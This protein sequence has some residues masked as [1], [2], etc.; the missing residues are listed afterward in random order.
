[1]VFNGKEGI[2]SRGM[3]VRSLLVRVNGPMDLKEEANI[4]KVKQPWWL[5][6]PRRPRKCS[7]LWCEIGPCALHFHKEHQVYYVGIT[8]M[9]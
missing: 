9:K 4:A 2:T 8:H 5:I 7:L 3:P 6:P 1:M